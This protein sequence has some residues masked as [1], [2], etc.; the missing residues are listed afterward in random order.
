MR[1]AINLWTF[2]AG[3]V[4]KLNTTFLSAHY[5]CHNP[6]SRAADRFVL[7]SFVATITL[8]PSS[9]AIWLV[10][11]H[12]RIQDRQM[13]QAAISKW[14]LS[15]VFSHESYSMQQSAML[16]RAAY[17]ATVQGVLREIYHKQS[18]MYMVHL[19]KLVQMT[20][21]LKSAL[22]HWTDKAKSHW[23]FA[24]SHLGS[25]QYATVTRV[26]LRALQ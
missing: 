25:P 15:H 12:K 5:E 7:R 17:S 21:I 8:L 9:F 19:R 16:P 26:R 2:S 22:Q 23:D 4:D 1:H 14:S 20:Q 13:L 11:I 10:Q 3:V 6:L 24:G 18:A